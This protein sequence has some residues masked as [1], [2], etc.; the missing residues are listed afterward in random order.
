MAG[1]P[2]SPGPD[3][4]LGDMR[5]LQGGE[6]ELFRRAQVRQI[7]VH[8]RDEDASRYLTDVESVLS[9][10]GICFHIK[11]TVL[12]YLGSLSD[13]T[14]GE[15]DMVA[16]LASVGLPI[17]DRL[18]AAIRTRPWF[19]R[20]DAAGSIAQWLAEGNAVSQNH[21]LGIMLA[22]VKERPDRIAEL[23]APEHEPQAHDR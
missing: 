19:D 11:E 23:L 12:A 14:A 20:L 22:A 5:V 18:W 2:A 21:A 13:S 8:L 9:E 6:H 1:P 7:L 15:W 10:P 17:A 16:H 3:G 4:T